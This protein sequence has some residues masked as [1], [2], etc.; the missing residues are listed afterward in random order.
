MA[1]WTEAKLEE[2]LVSKTKVLGGA[3]PFTATNFRKLLTSE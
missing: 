3:S 2:A 1:V